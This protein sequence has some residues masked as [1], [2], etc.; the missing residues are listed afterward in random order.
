MAASYVSC[1]APHLPRTRPGRIIDGDDISKTHPQDNT[2]ENPTMPVSRKRAFL[3]LVA[4]TS[5]L[6]FPVLGQG[7][8]NGRN[9][10]RATLIFPEEMETLDDLKAR[11][12]AQ[13]E[14]ADEIGV[15]HDFQ[16]VDRLPSSGITFR[17]RVVED[18]GRAYKAVHYD[19]GNGIV[20]GSELSLYVQQ[21]VGQSSE[22]KQT[23]DFGEFNLDDRGEL[24]SISI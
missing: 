24:I 23:P 16:F 11:H 13:L 9:D 15:R 10:G 4:F 19:H 2:Q 22:S 7:L 8:D 18:A 3:L 20:T 6:A 21:Q 1:D 17:H 12:Q 14:T 5:L